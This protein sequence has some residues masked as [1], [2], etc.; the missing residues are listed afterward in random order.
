M[1]KQDIVYIASAWNTGTGF[2]VNGYDFIITTVQT[3]GFSKNVT[4]KNS[5]IPKYQAKVLFVDFSSGLAFIEKRMDVE[6]SI[7]V[8]DFELTV[9]EQMVTIFRTNFYNDVVELK[10]EIIDNNFSHNNIRHLLLEE[11]QFNNSGGIVLNAKN[12]FVG[13]TKYI[14]K[15]KKKL[16][17]PAKYILKAMEEYSAVG[18]EAVRCTNCFNVVKIDQIRGTTCPICTSDIMNEAVNEVLPKLTVTDKEIEMALE[19][20][21]YDVKKSRLGQHIWEINEGSASIIVRYEPEQK[22]IVAF[23]LVAVISNNLEEIYKYL[24]I[25]NSK[26]GGL[27]FSLNN[28]KVILSA[29]YFIE[30]DFNE[31]FAKSIFDELFK[32]ADYYD[33]IIAD[34]QKK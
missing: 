27:S 16:V 5:F 12:E 25:E 6:N 15:T 26:I 10:T 28:D 19:N 7:D 31:H 17:L 33:D 8:S 13:V 23:S 14:E 4:V 18:G 11:D 1:K 24:L 30:E 32:K 3:V 20:L 34:M 29:P 21:N 2:I 9:I 22:F